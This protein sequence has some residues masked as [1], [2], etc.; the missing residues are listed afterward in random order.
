MSTKTLRVFT[1]DEYTDPLEKQGVALHISNM[2]EAHRLLWVER[3][4][5]VESD[6]SWKIL[7]AALEQLELL[8]NAHGVKKG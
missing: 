3:N 1:I 6:D 4:K 2:T 8:L 5:F 7:D